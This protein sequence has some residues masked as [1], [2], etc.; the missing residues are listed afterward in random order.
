MGLLDLLKK[1]KTGGSGTPTPTGTVGAA[2][3]A[4]AGQLPLSEAIKN[5]AI[6]PHAAV[7][8]P[9]LHGG[10]ERIYTRPETPAFNNP[11]APT[12][13]MA[14]A[15]SDPRMVGKTFKAEAALRAADGAASH[16]IV[17]RNPHDSERYDYVMGDGT[18]KRGLKEVLKNIG[19]GAFAGGQQGGLGGALAGAIGLG[20]RGAFDPEGAKGRRF[21]ILREPQL[22]AADAKREHTE[23]RATKLRA[24]LSQIQHRTDQDQLGQARIDERTNRPVNVNGA[25][26]NRKGEIL[27]IG[28]RQVDATGQYVRE[29]NPKTQDWDY[30]RDEDGNL[31][32]ANRYRAIEQS[33]V[34]NE[35]TNKTRSAIV[36]KQIDARKVEGDANRAQS[37]TNN[38]R[39]TGQSNTNNIRNNE[40]RGTGRGGKISAAEKAADDAYASLEDGKKRGLSPYSPQMKNAIKVLQKPAS[41]QYYE[42]GIGVNDYPYAKPKARAAGG[43]GRQLNGLSGVQKTITRAQFEKSVT[44]DFSGDRPAAEAALQKNNRIIKD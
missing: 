18:P 14:A 41:V 40:N 35:N 7:E 44:D 5:A 9:L 27:G 32:E 36:G 11:Q 30:S 17:Y 22:E 8:N 13:P 38:Q 29:W 21:D 23:D 31:V 19:T 20:V 3:G 42:S 39:T 25:L 2:T 28:K 6:T 1:L 15:Q 33:G 37:N 4:A 34:N 24:I 43:G 16:P 26:M 12:D 10:N